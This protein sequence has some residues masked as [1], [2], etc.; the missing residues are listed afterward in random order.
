MTF[1]PNEGGGGGY[2]KLTIPK[3]T[4]ATEVKETLKPKKASW[5]KFFAG[6]IL[7]QLP[8]KAIIELF[9]PS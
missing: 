7:K 5:L 8:C 1:Q 9:Y 2:I 6:K 4:E 3:E